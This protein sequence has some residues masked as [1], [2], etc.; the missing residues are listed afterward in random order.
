MAKRSAVAVGQ[1]VADGDEQLAAIATLAFFG[2]VCRP[3]LSVLDTH[4]PAV[5]RWRASLSREGVEPA[6]G[7]SHVFCHVPRH[8]R[9]SGSLSDHLYANPAISS[10]GFTG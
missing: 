4:R 8:A 3:R 1:A 5:G 7:E 2:T 6:R 9:G 10:H